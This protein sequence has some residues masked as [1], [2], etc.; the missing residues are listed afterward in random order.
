MRAKI[1]QYQ[2]SSIDDGCKYLRTYE[3]ITEIHKEYYDGRKYPL[4]QL[5]DFY[6]ELPNGTYISDFRIGRDRLIKEI[7][8]TNDPTCYKRSDDKVI[9]I[10]NSMGEF[11]GYVKNK[12]IAEAFI[13]TKL[14][15]LNNRLHIGK[16]GTMNFGN[17]N[18][19]YNE[20]KTI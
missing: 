10:Y 14:G 6:H 20:K 3:S 2:Y 9:K 13:N 1:K 5:N 19:I 16:K 18:F 11:V 4:Y 12:R 15:T 17:L 7:R 8:R